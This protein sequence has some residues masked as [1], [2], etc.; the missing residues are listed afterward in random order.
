M[1]LSNGR[2]VA[3]V[4]NYG[5]SS[6]AM[7]SKV[8]AVNESPA[9]TALHR[10][11]VGGS[12]TTFDGVVFGGNCIKSNGTVRSA[13][14]SL[15]FAGYAFSGGYCNDKDKDTV[16]FANNGLSLMKSTFGGGQSANGRS[17]NNTVCTSTTRLCV[18]GSAF[19]AGCLHTR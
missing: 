4:N 6:C 1:G 12:A 13:S 16:C 3:F 10:F 8:A 2:G 5:G 14:S 9:I 7:R 19:A 11:G 17:G 18:S 15:I